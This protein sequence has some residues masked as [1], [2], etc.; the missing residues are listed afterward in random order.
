[1]STNDNSGMEL[2]ATT[3]ENADSVYGG[4]RYRLSYAKYENSVSP[5]AK[6]SRIKLSTVI[7]AVIMFAFFVSLGFFIMRYYNK[8]VSNIYKETDSVS[9]NSAVFQPY[10]GTDSK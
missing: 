7:I 6:S 5:K 10:T 2:N 1:M 3:T 4:C 8:T 9:Q